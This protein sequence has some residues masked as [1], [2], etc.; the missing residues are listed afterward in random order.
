M[1]Y[2]LLALLVLIVSGCS[3]MADGMS[4]MAG[5]GVVSE[6]KSTFDD[7]RVVSV[8]PAHLYVKGSWGNTVRLGAR[9]SDSEPDL[10]ALIM[11]QSSSTS[12]AGRAYIGLQGLDINI[13]GEI[14][15]YDANSST[16][17]SN[18]GY[19]T[20]S[21]TIYTSSRNAVVVP[22]AVFVKMLEAKD[23]RIRIKTSDGYE[24][25][26]FSTER[27]PGGQGTAIL[28]MRDFR[29]KVEAAKN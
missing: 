8:S 23:C 15:S 25:S 19:N 29:A 24:D 6:S 20:V 3:S 4:K 28:A 18:S 21:K 2:L 13:D 16:K 5:L 17:L 12:T 1:K 22:Y 7:S 27:I 10:V 11:E 14:L 26:L 9:W